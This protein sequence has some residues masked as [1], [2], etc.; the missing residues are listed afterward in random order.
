M[1]QT[2]LWPKIIGIR[3]TGL[4]ITGTIIGVPAL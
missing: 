3:L 1:I 4:I 2:A